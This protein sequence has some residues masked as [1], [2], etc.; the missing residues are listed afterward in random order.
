[1]AA[2]FA[3]EIHYMSD[4]L[5]VKK[6]AGWHFLEGTFAGVTSKGVSRLRCSWS[7]FLVDLLCG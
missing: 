1:M 4:A 5:H 2:V 3:V 6:G 7:V